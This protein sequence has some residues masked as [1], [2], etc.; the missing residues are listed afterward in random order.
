MKLPFKIVLINVSIAIIFSLLTTL[1]EKDVFDKD[2]FLWFGL[3][4]LFGG[5][6]DLIAGLFLLLKEDKR[7]AQGFLLSG[8]ILILLGFVACSAMR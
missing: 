1:K 4:G 7:Y 6:V 8:G 2:F 5:A 3:S